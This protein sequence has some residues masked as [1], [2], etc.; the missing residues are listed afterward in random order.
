M[1]AWTLFSIALSFTSSPAVA[2]PNL[3]PRWVK[4]SITQLHPNSSFLADQLKSAP[5]LETFSIIDAGSANEIRGIYEAASREHEQRKIQGLTTPQEEAGYV[6]NIAGLSREI[7]VRVREYQKSRG[8]VRALNIIQSKEAQIPPLMVVGAI[9]YVFSD[10]PIQVDLDDSSRVVARA[11]LEKAVGRVEITSPF[12]NGNLLYTPR[13]P[14]RYQ[15]SV[16]RGVPLTDLT[17]SVSYLGTSNLVTAAVEKPLSPT[18]T[19]V[20]DSS[21]TMA[22]GTTWNETLRFIYKYNF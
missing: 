6:T 22:P 1:I 2:A 16:I 4:H 14:E 7:Y 17:S 19:A 11:N 15:F 5:E 8:R 21:K 13:E 9:A 20:V 18:V 12:A 10:N 3:Q